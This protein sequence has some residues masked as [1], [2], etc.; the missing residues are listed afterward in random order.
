MGH[1]EIEIPFKPVHKENKNFHYPIFGYIAKHFYWYEGQ[2]EFQIFWSYVVL[3]ATSLFKR[4][5]SI[6]NI[7]NVELHIAFIVCEK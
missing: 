5:F 2:L 4:P 6:C 1:H 3:F 7:E